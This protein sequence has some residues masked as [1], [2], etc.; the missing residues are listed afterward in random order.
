MTGF[1][2]KL[3]VLCVKPILDASDGRFCHGC[4]NPIH[5]A[6]ERPKAESRGCCAVCGVNLA[7][8]A[9]V[10]R[11]VDEHQRAGRND[12]VLYEYGNYADVPW[13][14]QSGTNNLFIGLG[15]LGCVPLSLWTCV[16]LLTGD[17]Y[18]DEKGS[19]GKLRTWGIV[20]KIWAVANV[21]V[22]TAII[23]L[24]LTQGFR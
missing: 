13:Y 16:N 8:A 17:V 1:V 5:F 10:Q 22:W 20:N 6:C 11:T 14:R 9:G 23:L 18:Y 21:L 7:A 19:D 3:C 4:R 2:G 15:L 24:V 12:V